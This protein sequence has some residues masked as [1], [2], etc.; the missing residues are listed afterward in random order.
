MKF[1]T[2]TFLPASKEDLFFPGIEAEIPESPPDSECNAEGSS[3][4]SQMHSAPGSNHACRRH[5]GMRRIMSTLFSFMSQYIPY[6]PRL[7][8]NSVSFCLWT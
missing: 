7:N 5:G 4:E 8:L 3:T 2:M 6:F 1:N